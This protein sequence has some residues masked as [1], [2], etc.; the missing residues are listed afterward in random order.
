MCHGYREGRTSLCYFTVHLGQFDEDDVSE[1]FLGV[2]GD[3]DGT[4]VGGVV[5]LDVLVVGCVSGRCRSKAPSDLRTR[6]QG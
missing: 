6:G 5:E 1:G 4:D 3:T 2:V